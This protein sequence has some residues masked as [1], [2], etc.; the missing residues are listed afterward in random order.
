MVV[1]FTHVFRESNEAV[2]V[3]ANMCFKANEFVWLDI[4]PIKILYFFFIEMLVAFSHIGFVR[5][6]FVLN[7]FYSFWFVCLDQL[8]KP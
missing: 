7:F 4:A 8:Y 6:A 3:M 1:R 2:N 5:R